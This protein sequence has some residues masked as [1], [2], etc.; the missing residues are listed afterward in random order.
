VG[1]VLELLRL[2]A[3]LGAILGAVEASGFS[4][5][6]AFSEGFGAAGG[7]GLTNITGGESVPP[8]SALSDGFGAAGGGSLADG[9]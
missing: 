4:A 6:S 5:M 9:T 7:G 8:S 1:S 3:G 2:G